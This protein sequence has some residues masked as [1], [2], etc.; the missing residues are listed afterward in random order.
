MSNLATLKPGQSA[1]IT[2]IRF[3]RSFTFRLAAMGFRIGKRVQLI[4]G[5][6]FAGPLHVRIGSTDIMLRRNEAQHI[7]IDIAQPAE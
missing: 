6:R 4:R 5:A 7:D 2:G 1:T 3:E